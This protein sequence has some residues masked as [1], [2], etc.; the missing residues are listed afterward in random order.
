[1]LDYIRANTQSFGVKVA[2][3]IIILVFV[4]WGVGSFTDTDS[5]RVL[6]K[7]NGEAILE[8]QFYRQYQQTENQLLQQGITK[9]QMKAQH[10]GRQVLHTMICQILVRQEAQRLGL[11]VTPRELREEIEKNS[12][13][14]NAQGKLDADSYA[15]GLKLLRLSAASFEEMMRQEMIIDHM[16]ELVTSSIWVNPNAAYDRY[17]FLFE[18]RVLDYIYLPAA[19]YLQSCSVT[20]DE[21]KSYYDA[22]KAEFTVPK[23]AIITYIKIDPEKIVDPKSITEAQLTQWYEKNQKLFT[24]KEAVRC[25]HILVPIDHNDDAASKKKA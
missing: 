23:K 1:M 4:F 24:Q 25:A 10:L 19:E 14:L 11:A 5:D 17:C 18:K 22:H 15:R 3:G 13:F 20:Q 9:Q 2:F 16:F 12:L 7:V 6:A 8:P 21:C